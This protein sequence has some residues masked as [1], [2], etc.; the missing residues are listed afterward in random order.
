[1]SAAQ[2]DTIYIDIDDEITAIIDKVQTSPKKIVALVLPKRAL[3]LQSIVNMKLLKR[4]AEQTK[5][6]IV[7]ITSESGLM[8]LAG[9]VGLHV[10]KSLD[11]RPAIPPPPDKLTNTETVVEN[12]ELTDES[13]PSDESKPVGEL[14]GLPANDGDDTIE[15]DNRD[16]AVPAAVA[17]SSSKKRKKFSI[18][19]FERFRTRLFLAIGVLVLLIVGWLM[20]AVI[21]PKATVAVTTDTTAIEN[22]IPFT[23]STTA[24]EFDKAAKVLP[25]ELQRIEKTEAEKVPAT[26]EKDVGTKATGS[27]TFINCTDDAVTIPAGRAASSNNLNFITQ[28]GVS[29]DEG[30]FTSTGECKSDGDHVGTTKVVAQSNGDKYNLGTRAYD[31]AGFG[32]GVRAHGS[33]MSGGTSK[34]AKV[35]TDNDIA[36][37]RANIAQRANDAA[38]KEIE[39]AL[40][41]AGLFPLEATLTTGDPAVTASPNVGE[42]SSEVTVT[43]ITAFSML[44]VKE[45]D[46]KTLLTEAASEKIDPDKQTIQDD[47]LSKATFTQLNRPTA[48]LASL[49]VKAVTIAGPELNAENI[50]KQVAGK[51]RG[52]V[53]STLKQLPGIKGV[54]VHYSPFWVL[55]TPSRTSNITITFEQA[56]ENDENSDSPGNQ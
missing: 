31:V 41:Q 39:Q 42:E 23:A 18:P 46:L 14:A 30:E 56:N 28:T 40:K 15:L 16:P 19:N 9:A 37:A 36:K 35:V 7:L 20:A 12:A 43:E 3:A 54:E 47:G 5:K 53:E 24:R 8:P 11:S 45:A 25:A 10:A 52:E 4:T 29:L 17:G 48:E 32:G 38:A 34:I 50:K 2:K 22:S 13:P 1:V 27:I 21:L 33:D 44:G 51:K 26:G 55:S 6:N 49:S